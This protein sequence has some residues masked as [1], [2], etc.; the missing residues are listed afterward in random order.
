[1]PTARER[2]PE[3]ASIDTSF[4]RG[5]RLLLMVADRGEVRADELA[6]ALE[7]PLSTVYRYVRTLAE[8]GFV[9][10]RE[11]RYRLGPGLRIGSGPVVTSE[12]LMRASDGVL[13]QL[14]AESGETAVVMRRIGLAAARLHQVEASQALRVTLDPDAQAPLSTGAFGLVLLAFAPDDIV[15]D[16]LAAEAA[17]SDGTALTTDDADT[18]AGV[19]RADLR[20]VARAGVATSLDE[21]IEGA[22]AVAVPILRPD[23]IIGAVGLIGPA[24]RCDDAWVAR[25]R[26]RLP[27]ASRRIAAELAGGDMTG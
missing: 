1:V 17:A 22:L 5:L 14:A 11:G 25:V 19:L 16:V 12:Q 8:F 13:H 4:A 2:P 26:R 9:E 15:A 3:E 27:A 21:P 6:P 18:R 10:R 23:G 7:M 24:S 20:R